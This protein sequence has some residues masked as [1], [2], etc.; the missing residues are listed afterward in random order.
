MTRHAAI[1]GFNRKI[2]WLKL[3]VSNNNPK[4]IGG[5]YLDC[6]KELNL[7]PW[8]TRTG[9][10]TENVTICGMHRFFHRNDTD[11]QSKDKSLLMGIQRY[12][13]IKLRGGLTF[14]RILLIVFFFLSKLRFT[15]AMLTILFS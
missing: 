7:I 13:K 3:G 5:Y 15:F 9:R 8:V 6:T 4:F 10:G 12:L 14:F 2:L 11:D 1:D